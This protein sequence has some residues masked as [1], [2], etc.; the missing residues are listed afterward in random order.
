MNREEY[1]NAVVN[2]IRCKRARDMV[3]EEVENHIED[4]T[5]AYME[6]GI[7][8]KVAEQKAVREMGDP[9][10]VG[11]SL[12][13]IHRP[14]MAWQVLA[15]IGVISVVSI[16]LQ[17]FMNK[18]YV[19]EGSYY[20][21]HQLIYMVTGFCIMLGIYFVDFS[22]IGRYAKEIGVVFCAIMFISVF[23]IAIKVN[24]M[25]AFIRVG[26]LAVSLKLFIYLYVPVYGAILYQ[27]RGEG[28]RA[29]VKAFMWLLLPVSIAIR[30]PSLITAVNLFL[31][32]FLLL[33]VAIAK[34]WYGIHKKL[35][36]TATWGAI[37][38]F[39]VT[40][41]ILMLNNQ[42]TIFPEYQSQ[43]IQ[44]FFAPDP[45]TFGYQISNVRT[46]VGS[47]RL[48]GSNDSGI[49]AYER[50]SYI[51]SDY[52]LTHIISYYGI[53]AA[54]GIVLLLIILIEKIFR[55]SMVQKNQ[56]GM[57]MGL[58]CGLVL[59]IQAATFV[60][61][62]IGLYPTT[63]VFLPLFSFGGTGTLVSYMLLGVLL[64]IYR[65][66]NISSPKTRKKKRLKITF[67]DN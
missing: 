42:K 26:P 50:L 44:T 65:Y 39:P 1:L 14:Q 62:N 56:M 34:N 58:G 12:D 23:F 47:S 33:T 64:S 28:Y 46:I 49:Q 3:K 43:R 37:V 8:D 35:V 17:Y 13:R 2:Q 22:I 27:Y 36:L 10:E 61:Q 18:N 21:F 24:G 48:V 54:V 52:L 15:L 57:M 31:M 59:T 30:M 20:F 67:V 38:V 63:T 60:L 7:E 51:N 19:A 55:I 29:L 53:L 40:T 25:S 6:M 16:F 9:V 5:K 4:Q 41:I 32:L 45:E 11:V 66:R